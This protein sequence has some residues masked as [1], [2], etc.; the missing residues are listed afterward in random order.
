L[1]PRVRARLTVVAA[2]VA[3]QTAFIV[4]VLGQTASEATSI[5][6]GVF[7]TAQ[8]ERGRAAY[9]GPCDRCHG[10][11]L[12][13]AAVDPD[14]LPAPPVAG[15]KFLRKWDGRSLA[16]LYEYT[17]A[18]MPTN[19]PGFLTE[20][21]FVDIIAYMLAASGALPGETDLKSDARTLAQIVVS[22]AP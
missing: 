7:T 2:L 3:S 10:S 1:A 13:G 19:N 20:Q 21:E 14:T 16:A 8:A 9:T 12:D 4:D 18:T 22:S 11:N 17:R 6:D 5:W 15:P